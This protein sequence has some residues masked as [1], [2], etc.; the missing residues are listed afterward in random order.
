MVTI[1]DISK[2]IGV[3]PGTVSKALNNYYGVSEETK[4]KV[5]A[6]AK[7]MGF[8]PNANARAIKAKYSHN[9]GILLYLRDKLDLCQFF[10]IQILN[11]FKRISEEKGYDITILSKGNDS[12][13]NAFIKHCRV[14]QLD[15]VIIF[16]DYSS[17]LVQELIN[18]DIPC[19]GFDYKGDKMP[20]V[21]S[22]NYEKTKELVSKLIEYGHEKILFITGEDNFIT[23]ERQRGYTDAF[24]E[25][26]KDRLPCVRARYTDANLSG[27]L[28]KQLYPDLKPTAIIYPDDFSATGGVNALRQMN[29]SIP[30][31]VSV[32][33]FDGSVFSEI[34][35]PPLTCICQDIE[36][37]GA[38]LAEK[39][40]KMIEEGDSSTD[41][42]TVEASIRF[43][44]SCRKIK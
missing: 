29:L 32:A 7:E 21:M 12:S 34:T 38:A 35:N 42:V 30:G 17:D 10:F 5:L 1:Y 43:T 14:R 15:G 31:D 22:D 37:I 20:G 8:V 26:G 27:E 40:I 9:L 6:I 36:K 39:L 28:T 33:A 24:N 41:T 25:A 2:K 4:A 19:V 3:A 23:R 11:E 18:S 16:G 44:D 13:V